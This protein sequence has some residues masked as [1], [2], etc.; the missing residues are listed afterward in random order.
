MIYRGVLFLALILFTGCNFFKKDT[1]IDPVARVGDHY[2]LKEEI[3]RLNT[4]NR[5][6]EDSLIYINNYINDWAQKQLLL[7]RARI[8]LS[9]SKQAE[10]E[11]LVEQY[12]ADLYINAYKEALVSKSMDTVVSQS[13]METFYEQNKANFKLNEDLIKLRYLSVSKEFT[14]LGE[15]RSKFR[16]FSE[17]DVADLQQMALKFKFYSLNDS[18]WVRAS[19]VIQKIPVINTDNQDKYLKKSQFFELSDSLGVYLVAVNDVLNRTETAPLVYVEPTVKKI[20]LNRRKLEFIRNLEKDLLNE[21]TGKKEF[22]VY[23]EK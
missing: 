3:S 1:V 5:S 13:E 20:I 7:D 10:F 22:E 18:V 8:N 6:S 23:L 11:R 12:R 2:L 9:A 14:E 19:E 21:A 16:D 4:G 15:V 17:D